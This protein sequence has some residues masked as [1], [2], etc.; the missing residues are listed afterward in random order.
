MRKKVKKK[1]RN[2][3]NKDQSGK[4]NIDKLWL[5]GEI[6]KKIK[7]LQKDQEQ[8]LKNQNNRHQIRRKTQIEGLAWKS[9]GSGVKTEEKRGCQCQ[10]GHPSITCIIQ[11]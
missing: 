9:K 1:I 6:K 3:K 2:Q 5:N 4:N 10:T 8:K 7:T 11:G